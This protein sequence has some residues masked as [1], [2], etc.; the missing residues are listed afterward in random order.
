MKGPTEVVTRHRSRA[1]AAP[2]SVDPIA[3]GWRT[4]RRDSRLRANW[5]VLAQPV[6]TQTAGRPRTLM[7]QSSRESAFEVATSIGV[8]ECM[9]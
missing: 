9:V 7:R 4:G 6:A 1:R 2:G 3:I 5:G 8:A